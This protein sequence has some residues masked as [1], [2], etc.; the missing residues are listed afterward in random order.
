MAVGQRVQRQPKPRQGQ[1]RCHIIQTLTPARG[2]RLEYLYMNLTNTTGNSLGPEKSLPIA[3]LLI[4]GYV[5][6]ATA[7]GGLLG[8]LVLES[9]HWDELR[10][11][12]TSVDMTLIAA[13]W[14]LAMVAAYIRG[15]RWK[16]LLYNEKTSA[17]RLF[18]IEQTGAALDT[19]SPL[20]VLDEV[21]QVGILALRDK[22]GL[23]KILATIA[24]QRTF[25][26]ATTVLALGAGALLLPQLREFLPWVAVGLVLGLLSLVALFSVGPL[27]NRIKILSNVR[28]VTQFASAIV[29]L[30]HHKRRSLAA[31]ALS[32]VQTGLIGMIGWLIALSTGL[33][34][35]IPAMI[36]ITLAIT[37]FSST[38]PGLP[39]SLGTFEFAAVTLL[40][41]WGIGR[42]DAIAFS[43]MLHAV[44]FLPPILFAVVFLPR[45]GLLSFRE[46]RALSNK[47]KA[48]MASAS[49]STEP[50]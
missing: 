20:R 19:L 1:R 17:T 30:R 33:Q 24:L 7:L 45:E 28:T 2:F 50:V 3:R 4:I 48:R 29:L 21:V 40:A 39:M 12:L 37:F 26:F 18:L 38:V 42:E 23:G 15:I 43:L 22:L 5:V 46:L 31:F 27:L 34:L 35:S 8:W 14:V 49:R 16:L 47:T 36:V 9:V 44:L 13:A 25:E 11:A 6:L 10:G 41:L 32:A